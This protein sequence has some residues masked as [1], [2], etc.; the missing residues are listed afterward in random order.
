MASPRRLARLESLIS[1][2]VALVFQQGINDPRVGPVVVTAVK[3]SRD[4]RFCKIKINPRGSKNQKRTTLMGLQ[5][6]TAMIQG[7]LGEVLHLRYI[8]QITF[9]ID[10]SLEK[11]DE[12]NAIFE[13]ISKKKTDQDKGLESR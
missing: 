10:R 3:L 5:S 11:M 6:A 13:K 9:E 7:R 12:I 2:E 8:P 1:Q 4:L